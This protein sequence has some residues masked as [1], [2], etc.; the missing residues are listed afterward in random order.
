MNI[1]FVLH[2]IF[3]ANM[4]LL[5]VGILLVR[6]EWRPISEALVDIIGIKMP[7]MPVIFGLIL[8]LLLIGLLQVGRDVKGLA[9]GGSPTSSAWATAG[10]LVSL[11]LLNVLVIP[12]IVRV[13]IAGYVPFVTRISKTVLRAE[14]DY[15]LPELLRS[16]DGTEIDDPALWR[17]K[18]RPELLALFENEVYGKVPD[19]AIAMNVS[20]AAI[21]NDALDGK[22][23]KKEVVLSF[24][25]NGKQLDSNVL[26]YVPKKSSGPVPAFLGL[27]FSGNHTIHPDAGH[28]ARDDLRGSRASRWQVE[29]V[30]ERGYALVTMHYEDIDPD[31]DGGFQNG[32]HQLFYEGDQDVPGPDE[33]GAIGAWSWGLSR[34]MDYLET[35]DDID[36]TR[37]VVMGHSRLGKTALWA[38]AQDER[39]AAV[40]S[41]NS[42]CMGAAL[43]RRKYGETIADITSSFPYW[44]C[45]NFA[46]YAGRE[47][48]L[49]ID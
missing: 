38:G 48:E 46:K 13:S 41:N 21:D 14:T 29:R 1:L 6:N 30:L 31:F 19:R 25:N 32:I 27:N 22:A 2:S 28:A 9:Q 11:V 20:S 47:N 24:T 7:W 33:W 26:L 45:A 39:F 49:P 15:V 23:I 3:S 18:R 34:I 12:I 8:S 40:I 36:H 4:A 44:F 16:S 10:F 17:E 43:S 42:G 35:D 5:L 37:V